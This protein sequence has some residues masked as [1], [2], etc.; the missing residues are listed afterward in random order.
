MKTQVAMLSIVIVNWNTRGS[1]A[2]CLLH[3]SEAAEGL[4]FQTIVVDNDSEDGSEEMLR[5]VYPWVTCIPVERNLGYGA[6]VNLAI[7]RVRTPHVLLLNPDV[8][9]EKGAIR[10]LLG[11]L[12]D[13]SG[14]AVA[15]GY[16]VGEDG[17]SQME[18]YYVPFPTLWSAMLHYTRLSTVTGRLRLTPERFT[19][20]SVR[21][22]PGACLLTRREVLE[23][24][25]PFDEDFFVWFEDVDWCYRA[26]RNRH[27]LG[28][29]DR[30]VFFHEGGKS[31]ETI[32][33]ETQKKWYYRSM[34]R[35]FRKHKGRLSWATLAGFI[36]TEEALV[37]TISALIGLLWS[38]L[39][40]TMLSRS[41]RAW[42]FI[43][44]LHREMKTSSTDPSVSTLGGRDRASRLRANGKG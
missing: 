8:V 13:N 41:K 40:E 7:R 31:F 11:Y 30:A 22:V 32:S 37:M 23:E 16:L 20:R 1:L 2:N 14:I 5:Q 21:Q 9:A 26:Y 4:P 36:L 17:R 3:L 44:F 27:A 38:P 28:I 29:C 18:D 42:G 39:R 43:S 19:D 10:I 6:G 35:F 33:R 34:L 15:G 24:V 25:G 12:R